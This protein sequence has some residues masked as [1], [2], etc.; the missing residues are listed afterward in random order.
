M[1][2]STKNQ[3]EVYAYGYS[4][5][6]PWIEDV[7]DCGGEKLKVTSTV[8]WYDRSLNTVISHPK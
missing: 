3:F 8:D 7:F 5:W 6:D 1:T 2:L 4:R